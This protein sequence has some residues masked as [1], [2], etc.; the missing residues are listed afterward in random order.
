MA[1]RIGLILRQI[2]SVRPV[3]VGLSGTVAP[4][5][6]SGDPTL[7]NHHP[8]RCPH[9]RDLGAKYSGRFV[10]REQP[11]SARGDVPH[12]QWLGQRRLDLRIGSMP[13]TARSDFALAKE[14]VSSRVRS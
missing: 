14:G 2:A 9:N 10:N 5:P 11:E 8:N 13:I 3:L 1:R 7:T 6:T 12:D 4:H